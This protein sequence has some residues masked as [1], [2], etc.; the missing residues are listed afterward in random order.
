MKEFSKKELATF[1]GCHGKPA[2]VAYKGKVYD[3]TGSKLWKNGIHVKRHKAGTDL[4]A[5][6][7]AAPH[8]EHAFEGWKMVGHIHYQCKGKAK[9]MPIWAR[10]T[11]DS[12]SHPISVHFPQAFLAFSPLFLLAFYLF[13]E[14]AFER[15]AFYLQICG[16]LLA[17]PTYITGLIHWVYK[18][19]KRPGG[20]YHFKIVAPLF[21]IALIALTSGLHFM[22]IPLSPG[23]ADWLLGFLYFMQ[24]PF[25]AAIGHAGGKIVFG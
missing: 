21:L 17:I 20:I 16:L 7:E 10:I 14:P 15:T 18:F 3:V 13:Q 12:H 8:D 24:M 2:Y 4:S 25:V 23:E 22:R 19:G 11:L 9:E 1:D 6:M 5:D